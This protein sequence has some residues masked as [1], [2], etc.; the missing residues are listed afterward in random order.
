M[1]TCTAPGH[2][3][4]TI[5]CPGGCIAVYYEPNGPCR[6]GCYG[7]ASE[8]FKIDPSRTFSIQ[9]NGMSSADLAMYLDDSIEPQARESLK[10]GSKS[11]TLNLEHITLKELLAAAS[12]PG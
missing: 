7:S 11:L 8:P 3:T 1:S 2:S 5:T 12:R 4:C 6:T 10:L 9:I